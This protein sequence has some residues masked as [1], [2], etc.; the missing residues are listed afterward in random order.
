MSTTVFKRLLLVAVLLAALS[1]CSPKSRAASTS[2]PQVWPVVLDPA[3]SWMHPVLN[4]CIQPIEDTTLD[5]TE[6]ELPASGPIVIAWGEVNWQQSVSTY[7]L[8]KD[9]FVLGVNPQNPVDQISYQTVRSI[10]TGT[11][12]EWAKVKQSDSTL[13]QIQLWLYPPSSLLQNRLMQMLNSSSQRQVSSHLAPDPAALTEAVAADP[14]AIGWL[15]HNALTTAIKEV[16]IDGAPSDSTT[17]PILVYLQ[18]KPT[19][20]QSAWLFC[21]QTQ[22]SKLP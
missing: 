17:L 4:S 16:E 20:A 19:S 1:A 7:Q 15:P 18:A 8:G 10:F 5:I 12:T 13:S 6:I 3:L 2:E 21:I 11:T 9:H 22:L 14:A